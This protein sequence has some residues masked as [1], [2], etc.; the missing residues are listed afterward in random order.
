MVKPQST[1]LMTNAYDD[2]K[3]QEKAIMILHYV[4]TVLIGINEIF[5]YEAEKWQQYTALK[6]IV[7]G[8]T[9]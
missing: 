3:A 9:N 7:L 6:S 1:F 5:P 8:E 2:S 4:R